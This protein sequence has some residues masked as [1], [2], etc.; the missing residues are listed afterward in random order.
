MTWFVPVYIVLCV[1]VA[2]YGQHTR[3]GFWG[4]LLVSVFF[5]PWLIGIGLVLLAPY[6]SDLFSPFQVNRDD[7]KRL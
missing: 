6:R 1:L 4:I 7:E 3:L 5:T 2:F